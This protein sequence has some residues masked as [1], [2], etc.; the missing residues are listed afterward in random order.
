MGGEVLAI[1]PHRACPWPGRNDGNGAHGMGGSGC[2]APRNREAF[3]LHK[4]SDACRLGHLTQPRTPV[5]GRIDPMRWV[6]ATAATAEAA[7]REG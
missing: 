2:P 4:G 6:A 7:A 1:D 5:L 3:F